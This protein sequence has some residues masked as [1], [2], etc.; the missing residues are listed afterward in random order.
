MLTKSFYDLDYIIEL[1]EKR[2]EQYT[3]AYQKVLE[4]LTNIILIYSAIAIFLVPVIQDIFF[5]ENSYWFLYV[6]F[7]SFVIIFFTS[8]IYTIRL[9][10]PAKVAHLEMPKIYYDKYRG[11]YEKNLKEK[12]KIADLL[13]S[14]YIHELETALQINDEVFH[15]KNAFYYNAL[16]YA[17][18]SAIPYLVCLGFHIFKREDKIH[19]VKI[20]EPQINYHFLKNDSMKD[21]KNKKPN[22][23][24][25]DLPGVDSSKV[26]P[27]YPRLIKENSYKPSNKKK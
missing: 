2:L 23:P 12:N 8:V 20:V 21:N 27:S 18:F 9:M 7:S 25:S 11:F 6:S 3:A 16:I 13:N 22:T 17:L 5:S 10:I 14:S 4:R 1:N 15:R 24:V 19:Q 26:I